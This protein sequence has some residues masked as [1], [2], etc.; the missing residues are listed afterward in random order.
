ML[1]PD[2][3]YRLIDNESPYVVP[4]HI[5]C[6]VCATFTTSPLRLDDGFGTAVCSQ[7]CRQEAYLLP[8]LRDDACGDE[9]TVVG[10]AGAEVEGHF[11]NYPPLDNGLADSA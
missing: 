11:G 4:V 8:W 1:Y 9:G 10:Q 6:F 3:M 2:K 7:E 5:R